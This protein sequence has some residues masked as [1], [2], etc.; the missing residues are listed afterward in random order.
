VFSGYDANL[1]TQLW[2]AAR[3]L[4][5]ISLLLA[6]LWIGRKLKINPMLLAYGVVVALLLL[7]I[8]PWQIFPDCFMEGRGLT[9]FKKISEYIISLILMTAIVLLVQ[10]RKEFDDIVF[11]LLNWSILTTIAAELAFTFYVSVY[12]LSNLVG[13]LFKVVSFY[14]IY[15]AL[16]ETGLVRPYDLLFRN[17]KKSEEALRFSES[18]FSKAFRSSPSP[19]TISSLAEG[20]YIEVNDS[21]LQLMG[22]SREEVIGHTTLDLNIWNQPEDRAKMREILQEQRAIRDLECAFRTKSGEVRIALL[23]AE[24]IEVNGEPHILVVTNDITERKK[25]EEDLR[26]TRDELEIRVRQRTAE[27]AEINEALQMKIVER[28][29]IENRLKATNGLLN[30]FPQKSSRKEY[31]DAVVNLLR[32]WSQCRC[33]GIRILLEKGQIPYESYVGFSQE[34]WESENWL[35]VKNDQCVCIRIISGNPEPQDAPFMTPAGSFR[36]GNMDQFMAT[37]SAEDRLRFRCICPQSGF[38]SVAVIPLRYGKKV[39]GAIHLADERE[40]NIPLRVVEFIESMSSPIGEAV[41]RFNLEDDLRESEN[42]LHHL[43]SQ[44][45]VAQ[46]NERRRIARELHDSIGQSLAAIK[47]ILE[48]KLNQ[49]SNGIASPGITLEDVI[50]MIQK[51]IEESRRISMD[52]WPSVLDDLGILSAISWFCRQFGMVYSSISIEKQLDIREDEVPTP[53][54]VVI[55]RVLQEALNNIAKHSQAARVYISLWKQDG[56]IELTIEDNGIGFD[57]ETSRKGL[58][59]VSMK[60]RVEFSGGMLAI[61]SDLGSGTTIRETWT[62]S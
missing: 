38:R 9:P 7:A 29:E 10:R 27:L 36:C 32:T 51:A 46:E 60:E 16:I 40:G 26:R 20:R 50:P 19:V 48:K 34:F 3:Y 62:I 37:L 33:V 31:L 17:L 44:L 12:G 43:S 53:L 56:Q 41:H 52:L 5:S 2:I 42:R 1:P 14:L 30:L 4:Q 61:E 35:S 24:I 58:G 11:Q 23:A 22:Y 21:F 59:L 55:Y 13:H 8:F 15:K 25:M 39:L 54:K 47:F 45:L 28:K 57:P 18:K 49:L 6:P